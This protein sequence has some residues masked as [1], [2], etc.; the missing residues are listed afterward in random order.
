VLHIRLS[1]RPVANNPLVHAITVGHKGFT[2]TTAT[3]LPISQFA[4]A[5]TARKQF[6]VALAL[7]LNVGHSSRYA[8]CSV[9]TPCVWMRLQRVQFPK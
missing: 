6:S 9:T 4:D 1:S 8:V 3:H 2:N 7:S 5:R